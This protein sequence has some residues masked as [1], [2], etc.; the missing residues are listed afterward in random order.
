MIIS[1]QHGYWKSLYLIRHC[2]QLDHENIT[3]VFNGNKNLQKWYL[4]QTRDVNEIVPSLNQNQ[5]TIIKKVN[6]LKRKVHL[7]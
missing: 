1:D 3:V 4:L 5:N 7:E 2:R 6:S